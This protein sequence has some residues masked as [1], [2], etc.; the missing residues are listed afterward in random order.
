MKKLLLGLVTLLMTACGSVD[1]KGNEIIPIGQTEQAI[2]LPAG[3]GTE[4]DMTA[5]DNNWSG[6]FCDAPDFRSIAIS[7]VT[8]TCD[9]EFDG[10]LK[11]AAERWRKFMAGVGWKVLWKENQA[12][13]IGGDQVNFSIA[14]DG[15]T[16][17]NDLGVTQVV[18]T[19]DLVPIFG[20]Y[21]CH[22]AQFGDFCQFQGG[23]IKIFHN[24]IKSHPG[25]ASATATKRE[26]FAMNVAQHE[27]YHAS[28]LGHVAGQPGSQLMVS[29]P[30]T[31]GNT[32]NF[33]TIK[34]SPNSA[35]RDQLACYNP[36]SG[37]KPDNNP[38]CP[39]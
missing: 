14:C 2:Y 8:N 35:Q 38:A 26:N 37:T 21:E 32:S 36:R 1:E 33:W 31:T 9:N 12:P 15:A 23:R 10:Y 3:Y 39:L 18:T 24:K 16:G 13:I 5:C 20:S 25:W 4:D 30:P 7:V 11:A 34:L 29:G 28:G 6:G 27:L 22:D 19:P 17:G